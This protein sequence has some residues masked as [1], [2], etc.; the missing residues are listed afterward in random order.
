MICVRFQGWEQGCKLAEI[1]APDLGIGVSPNADFCVEM[2]ESRDALRVI[3]RGH[4]AMVSGRLCDLGRGL[5][6]LIQHWDECVQEITQRPCFVRCGA[7]VDAS[8][9]AVPKVSTIKNLLRRCALMGIN[10]LMLYTE[11]TYEVP[12]VPYFGYLRG[13][14]Q[15]SE[16][17]ELDEYAAALGIEMIPCIQT[18][19]HLDRVLHWDQMAQYRDTANVLLVDMEQTYELLEKMIV[20]AS[21]PFRTN[22]IHIGMDEAWGLGTGEY[23]KWFGDHPGHE[24][25]QRHLMRVQQILH[26]HGLHGMMWSDM[27][28]RHSSPDNL[29]YDP[30]HPLSP[31]IAHTASK[32]IDL[33]YWDYYHEDVDAYRTYIQ[34]HQLFESNVIFAGGIWTWAGPTIH[35][36]KTMACTLPA[37]QACKEMGVKEVIATMW[38]DNGGECN[39]LNAL[40]GMQVYAE[41]CYTGEYDQQSVDARFKVCTGGDGELYRHMGL[42]HTIDGVCDA[43]KEPANPGRT[44]LY[45]DPLIPLSQAD[46]AEIDVVGHYGML[47]QWFD[48]YARPTGEWGLLYDFYRCYADTMYN[49]AIWHRDAAVCV[50]E[51]DTARGIELCHLAGT[52]ENSIH[53]FRDAA[54][55]L[56]FATNRPY[57]FE[58]LDLRLG[59]LAARYES[60]QK[61]MEEYVQGRVDDIPELS[62]EKLPLYRQPDGRI[63]TC[64]EWS[65]VISA[66]KI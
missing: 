33:V 11:D 20:A 59:G 57:G 43:G 7:M 31:D 44:L 9:N 39:L 38:G 64:Y 10:T 18:L 45:Q 23:R 60:A 27:Y 22:R 50:R 16:L 13:A 6:L 63:R 25:M 2:V 17:H 48:G 21:A 56:W 5:S 53:Q 58:I 54:R 30:Q 8:R 3:R 34:Q 35:H 40:Y 15:Q 47:K 55:N 41:Y 52:L 4:N 29:Y 46:Y 1:V 49:M 36:P 24:I 37:L 12:G 65:S 19:G 26:K 42:F 66:C 51:H 61:R 28:F 14:Y 32:D 62:T